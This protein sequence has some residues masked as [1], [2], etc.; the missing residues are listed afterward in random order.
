MASR[1]GNPKDRGN[2]AVN[3]LQLIRSYDCQRNQENF[4]EYINYSPATCWEVWEVARATSAAPYHFK[5][6]CTKEHKFRD[7]ATAPQGA[8]PTYEGLRELKE[9]KRGGILKSTIVSVGTCTSQSHEKRW[10][11]FSGLRKLIRDALDPEPMHRVVL[12]ETNNDKHINY[13]RLNNPEG[14]R[15]EFDEWKPSR[16]KAQTAQAAKRLGKPGN[17]EPGIK[18]V[19]QI[20]AAFRNWLSNAGGSQ[21]LERCADELVKTRRA[22]A[23][24]FDRWERYADCARYS[25]CSQKFDSKSDFKTHHG[26]EHETTGSANNDDISEYRQSWRYPPRNQ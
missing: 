4:R 2:D 3:K 13:Y 25:C 10:F 9:R 12:A 21:L 8:N 24:D 17:S 5:S 16:L 20:E 19:N 26:Q 14:L 11:G 6:H 15:I 23:S 22:R 18:T 1:A 7:G